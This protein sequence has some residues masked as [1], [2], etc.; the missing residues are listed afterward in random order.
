MQIRISGQMSQEWSLKWGKVWPKTKKVLKKKREVKDT[1]LTPRQWSGW[2]CQ[3]TPAVPLHN[4]GYHCAQ[5]SQCWWT[6]TPRIKVKWATP[7]NENMSC[8]LDSTSLFTHGRKK[9]Q[10]TRRE[11]SFPLRTHS[12]QLHYKMQTFTF[13]PLLLLLCNK[14]QK[15]ETQIPDPKQDKNTQEVK[16]ECFNQTIQN[17]CKFSGQAPFSIYKTTDNIA[18]ND[19]LNEICFSVSCCISL[20]WNANMRLGCMCNGRDVM[21]IWCG[22]VRKTMRRR[23]GR[24]FVKPD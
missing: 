8:Y 20:L 5:M 19:N 9:M 24:S 15:Q 18:T 6:E 1:L 14:R 21:S 3:P 11:L 4:Q 23:K 7:W 13:K 12:L 17:M 2:E 22:N 16:K 10:V